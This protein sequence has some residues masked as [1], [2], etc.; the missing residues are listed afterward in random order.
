MNIRTLHDFIVEAKASCYVSG[1]GVAASCRTRSHDH[2]LSLGE[3]HYLDSDFGGGDFAGQ[4]V[5]WHAGQPVW[6]MN[7]FGRI[8][9]AWTPS[10][11]DLLSR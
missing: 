6:A 3:C 4:E 1:S 2:G 9:D 11:P 7:C 8:M 5:V 10:G